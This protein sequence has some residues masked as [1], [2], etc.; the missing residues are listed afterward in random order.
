M[1]NRITGDSAPTSRDLDQFNHIN[2]VIKSC[3]NY[4]DITKLLAQELKKA[5]PELNREGVSLGYTA[6]SVVLSLHNLD[7]R[8][9]K[10]SFELRGKEKDFPMHVPKITMDTIIAENPEHFSDK[11]PGI[12]LNYAMALM[13]LCAKQPSDGTPENTHLNYESIG[14]LMKER[15]QPL[16]PLDVAIE[17]AEAVKF[18]SDVIECDNPVQ[19]KEAMVDA[20]NAG[21]A[22][23]RWWVDQYFMQDVSRLVLGG[24]DEFLPRGLPYSGQPFKGAKYNDS[25]YQACLLY[26]SPSPRD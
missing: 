8:P 19:L 14:M 26:T 24:E 22:Q 10:Y 21:T 7:K 5:V 16:P 17:C 2:D 12:S 23:G 6:D 20:F 13:K 11:Q 4:R 9:T 1:A 25:L 3:E 15:E 18:I